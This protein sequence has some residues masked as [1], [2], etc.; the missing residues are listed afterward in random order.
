M[1]LK[2][3]SETIKTWKIQIISMNI[4]VWTT[5]RV[6]T[7]TLLVLAAS[8]VIIVITLISQNILINLAGAET[9]K[10]TDVFKVIVSIFGI[11]KSKGDVVAIV[12][13]NNGEASRVK[14]L[15]SD[16][17]YV[18]PLNTSEG[19]TGGHLVEYVATFPNVVVNAGAEYNACIMTTKDLELICKTGHNSPASR[20]EFIDINLD[21]A[22]LS[23]TEQA[24][25]IEEEMGTVTNN[26]GSE[27]DD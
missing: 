21:E 17:P 12:T 11:D 3:I 27:G 18:V 24:G 25:D 1:L 4:L 8:I 2:L 6:I 26:E 15:E 23:G 14:F 20:P 19:E 13:V 5:K 22:I 10:G 16:A 9:G 7:N